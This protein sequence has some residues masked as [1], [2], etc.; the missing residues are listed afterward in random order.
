M[1]SHL[2]MLTG[3]R[4]LDFGCGSGELLRL[5]KPYCLDVTGIE[6]EQEYIDK[7]NKDG[8]TCFNSLDS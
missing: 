7:L 6:L 2:N 8:I 1:K 4:V 5:I 3:K